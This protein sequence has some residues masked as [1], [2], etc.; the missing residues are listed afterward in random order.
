MRDAR[1]ATG[2]TP[3]GDAAHATQVAYDTRRP[4]QSSTKRTRRVIEH[5]GS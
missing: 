5:T 3:Q 1:A 4:C 2:G